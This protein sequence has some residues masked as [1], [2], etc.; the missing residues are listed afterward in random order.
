MQIIIVLIVVVFTSALILFLIKTDIIS[1]KEQSDVDVLNSQF[2]YARESGELKVNFIKTCEQVTNNFECI[3]EKSDFIFGDEIHFLLAIESPAYN[4]KINL[5][6]NYEVKN[7]NK[8]LILAADPKDNY[9]FEKEVITPI[10]YIYFNDFVTINS[11]EDGEYVA[12]FMVKNEQLGKE[13]GASISF[14]IK[15]LDL[16]YNEI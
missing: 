1:P 8:Q 14:N 12:T 11:G 4:G 9:Y 15:S 2:L 10:D 16:D 5:V 3:N 13:I 7:P 6:E